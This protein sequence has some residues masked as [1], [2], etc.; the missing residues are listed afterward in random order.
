MI[1]KGTKRGQKGEK[2]G[3]FWYSSF[4]EKASENPRNP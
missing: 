3:F 2:G 1:F 4:R